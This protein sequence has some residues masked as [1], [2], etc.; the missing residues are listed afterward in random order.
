ALAGAPRGA[1]GMDAAGGRTGEAPRRRV[2]PASR[3]VARDA[4]SPR[5]SGA[6]AKGA[7]ARSRLGIA[8]FSPQSVARHAHRAAAHAA[9]GLGTGVAA[10]VLENWHDIG[11]SREAA[12]LAA[13]PATPSRRPALP[14]GLSA[15]ELR[16]MVRPQPA[17]QRVAAPAGAEIWFT[18][19]EAQGQRGEKAFSRIDGPLLGF[20]RLPLPRAYQSMQPGPMHF[21]AL[22]A[23]D[24]ND[25]GWP[26]VAV[27]TSFGVFL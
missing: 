9:V 26:D 21:G 10:A 13:L 2:V 11:Q 22:A 1:A 17:A 4:Q 6:G 25:D 20:K 3:V 27:G 23:G 5:R 8:A 7:R 12:Q 19:F 14:I 18:P 16:T 24:Y 15:A